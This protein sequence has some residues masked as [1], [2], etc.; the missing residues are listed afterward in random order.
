LKPSSSLGGVSV[1][2][3]CDGLSQGLLPEVVGLACP[4]PPT[5]VAVFS[6]GL[7]VLVVEDLS[8]TILAPTDTGLAAPK[9]LSLAGFVDLEGSLSVGEE[10][11][12]LLGLG[13]TGVAEPNGLSLLSLLPVGT[14]EVT[15][16]PEPNGFSLFPVGAGEGITGLAEPNGLSL[17]LSLLLLGV[18]EETVV[19]GLA[20]PNGLSLPVGAVEVTGLAEPNGLSFPPVGVGEII[21]FVA[22]KELTLEGVGRTALADPKG[23]SLPPL[24]TG[25]IALAEPKGLSVGVGETALAE[26]KG[27]SLT[28]VGVGETA[29]A[30]PNGFSLLPVGAVEGI[31]LGLMK[32][33]SGFGAMGDTNFFSGIFSQGFLLTEAIG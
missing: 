32:E 19:T 4:P 31:G 1:E 8:S 14:G 22:P 25:E 28:P 9:G 24:G 6:Q 7:A 12:T 18:G 26:P 3:E 16:L 29:L 20:E 13:I 11:T 5:C 2:V 23:L 21:G 30:E 17:P 15:G 27:L 33:D 10:V